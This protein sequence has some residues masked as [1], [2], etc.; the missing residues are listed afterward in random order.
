MRLTSNYSRAR[1]LPLPDVITGSI[2]DSEEVYTSSSID[3]LIVSVTAPPE[4]D[5]FV[6]GLEAYVLELESLLKSINI[7][8]QHERQLKRRY[9]KALKLYTG[10]IEPANIEEQSIELD[11]SISF[12]AE[13]PRSITLS[14][15]SLTNKELVHDDFK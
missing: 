1:E 4:E 5:P 14:V 15:N 9:A 8:K 12:S 13:S 7:V 3:E 6:Q 11:T 10:L 2:K